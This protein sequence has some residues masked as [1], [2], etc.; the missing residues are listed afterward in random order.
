MPQEICTIFYRGAFDIISRSLLQ[1]STVFY[2]VFTRHAT[3]I[4][5]FDHNVYMQC[6]RSSFFGD[7]HLSAIE[8][9]WWSKL[10]GLRVV[11]GFGPAAERPRD[12]T[13]RGGWVYSLV[14]LREISVR[15][16]EIPL[17]DLAR[18]STF[19][20]VLFHLLPITIYFLN[21]QLVFGVS[22]T[23]DGCD[24]SVAYGYLLYWNNILF[25]CSAFLPI[26]ITWR[27]LRRRDLSCN[28][29]K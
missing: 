11:Q 9:E 22:L 7:V 24:A 5:K 20:V 17:V 23:V 4:A 8:L 28:Q 1:T 3:L 21:V 16:A 19:Y 29:Q 12:R 6:P 15:A 10:L 13:R 18:R 14:Q 26:Q 2:S 25:P 27:C